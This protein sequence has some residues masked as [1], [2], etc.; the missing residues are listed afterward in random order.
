MIILQ[1]L[2]I[3][4]AVSSL[5]PVNIQTLIF[6]LRRSAKVSGTKGYS[7]SSTAVA[8]IKINSF[9]ISSAISNIFSSYLGCPIQASILS[10]ISLYSWS[11]KTFIAKERVLRPYLLKYSN[12][13]STYCKKGW[14][15]PSRAFI[16]L[17]A[18]FIYNLIIPFWS[19]MIVLILFLSLLNSNY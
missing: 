18:P 8:P 7:L 19:F 2:P 13:W 4:S 15:L 16:R 5:S 12:F 10:L 9:S 3:F 17:S 1:L 6:A 11:V 14:F